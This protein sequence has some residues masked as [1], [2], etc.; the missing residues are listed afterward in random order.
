M[1]FDLIITARDRKVEALRFF[2]FL[3]AQDEAVHV[4]VLFADQGI[5]CEDSIRLFF[6]DR[7]NFELVVTKVP[8]CGLS[9][10]RNA[11]LRLGL[12]SEFV[13]FPDDDCWYGPDVLRRV[14]A[15]FFEMPD[16][17]CI[18]TNVFDPDRSLSYGGRALGVRIPISFSNIFTLP[19]SVGIFVRRPALESVGARFCESL[20]AGT[21]LG[22]GEETEL[23]AR[24]LESGAKV[25]YLGDISVFHPVPV[26]NSSDVLKFYR[27]GVGYGFISAKFI[28]RGNSVVFLDFFR[29]LLRSLGGVFL[30]LFVKSKRDVYAFRLLGILRGASLAF[31]RD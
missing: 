2:R 19:I 18:C 13:G 16:V 5:D 26:Y 21:A 4:R 6:A 12:A 15:A 8:F 29:T 25:V 1:G 14:E 20:G 10:A 27:Y 17:Q 23:I 3:A 9:A 22:S 31:F 11:A 7:R 30:Y 24:L 28:F